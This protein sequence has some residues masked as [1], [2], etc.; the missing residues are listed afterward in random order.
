MVL[1]SE[2][3]AKHLNCPTKSLPDRLNH[4]ED[5]IST[6]RTLIG[7]KVRTTYKD[8]N[9]MSKV[10]FIGGISTKGAALTPAYGRLC[11]PYNVNIAA[12]FYARHRIRLHHPYIPCIIERFPGGGEDRFYPMELL[13]LIEEKEEGAS[14]SWLGQ[15]FKEIDDRPEQRPTSS[16]S[17]NDSALRFRIDEEADNNGRDECTQA[18]YTCW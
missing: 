16:S 7:R 3:T 10:F 8:R 18:S 12:H 13:E 2:F 5:R 14:A 15:M 6:L 1:V 11:Q 4:P 9:G 17:S